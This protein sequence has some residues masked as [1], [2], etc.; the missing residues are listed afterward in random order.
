MII[1]KNTIS[2]NFSDAAGTYDF[3]AKPQKEIAR[4]LVELLAIGQTKNNVLDLGCGTGNIID[5]VLR[6]DPATRILGIDIAP[7]MIDFCTKRWNDSPEIN[8]IKDDICHFTPTENYDLILSSCT[9]QWIKDIPDVIKKFTNS[10][11]NDGILAIAVL[12]DGSFSELKNSYKSL[13]GSNLP[14]PKYRTDN[15]YV[16][17]LQTSNLKIITAKVETVESYFSG[18]DLLKYFKNIGATFKHKQKL[19][20]TKNQRY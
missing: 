2:R 13:F 16:D 14:G 9:F 12:L 5:Q 17:A 18:L 19:F 6:L 20:T 1:E 3:W 7:G 8:F 11:C 10:L 4:R 15:Y